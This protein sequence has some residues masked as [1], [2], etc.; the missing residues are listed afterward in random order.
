[1]LKKL[2]LLLGL[3]MGFIS[4]AQ[5]DVLFDEATEAY[6]NGNYEK[7]IDPYNSILESNVHSAALYYNLGNAYY[8]LNE[9]P[10]SIYFYEKSLLL[11]PDDPEVKTNLGYAQNMTLDAI[12]TLPKTGFSRIYKS[13]T[14]TLTFDE[15]AY[16]SVLCMLLFVILYIA[17]YYFQ[18]S[19]KKRLAFISSIIALFLCV[20]FIVFASIEMSSF[21]S[22]NPAII[23]ADEVTVSSEPNEASD[24][25][26]V[27]H[28]GTKVNVVDSL[29]NYSKIRLADGKTGWLPQNQLKLLK[30]F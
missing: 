13:I 24:E 28:S 14:S 23:F 19:T 27:L 20:V 4:S 5:N 8:K 17:F 2:I 30:D 11:N 29:N 22:D 3:L 18:Y 21:T 26:F 9:I 1:M 15:W 6:N 12:E 7:A 16:A 10:E 25:I